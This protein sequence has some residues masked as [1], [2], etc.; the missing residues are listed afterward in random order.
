MRLQ[1]EVALLYASR[2]ELGLRLRRLRR[3][4]AADAPLCR[5]ARFYMLRYIIYAALLYA[6]PRRRGQ[7]DAAAAYTAAGGCAVRMFRM[8]RGRVCECVT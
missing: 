7:G 8:F 4:R 2:L 1:L 6:A 3:L 5:T